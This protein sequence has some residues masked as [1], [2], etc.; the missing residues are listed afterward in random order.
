MYAAHVR[1]S[2]TS[3]QSGWRWLFIIQGVVTFVVAVAACFILPDEPLTTWWLN[4]EERQLAHAR[5]ARDT[6]GHSAD[7]SMLAGL[8]EAI[9]DPKV[10]VFVYMQHLLVQLTLT[11]KSHRE[12]W[13]QKLHADDRQHAGLLTGSHTRPDMPAVLDSG[14]ILCRVGYIIWPFQR[15]HLAHYHRERRGYLW[16]RTRLR[17]YERRREILRHVRLHHWHLWR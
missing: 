15:A 12:L 6:V 7:V 4:P 10:W 1:H 9:R 5:V 3:N 14:R 2:L 17:D 8:K 11:S 13:F 16:F